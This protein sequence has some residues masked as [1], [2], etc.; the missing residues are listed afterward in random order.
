M[1]FQ[2]IYIRTEISSHVK[3]RLY[4]LH[5]ALNQSE[6]RVPREWRQLAEH[7]LK[8]TDHLFQN[9]RLRVGRL[10]KF[11]LYSY[12]KSKSRV[13]AKYRIIYGQFMLISFSCL[14]TTAFTTFEGIFVDPQVDAQFD[15]MV[16]VEEIVKRINAELDGLW[17]EVL[18]TDGHQIQHID[19]ST[20][21]GEMVV[22]PDEH[23]QEKL[24][25]ITLINFFYSLTAQFTCSMDT[26]TIQLIPLL[27]HCSNDNT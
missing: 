3:A 18:D 19:S 7:C 22:L 26:S 1:L 27:A 14:A 9:V 25:L 2:L 20:S 6:W 10:L 11:I 15:G 12:K 24:R 13:N 23:K 8:I 4:L 5:C 21:L 16:T 17:K